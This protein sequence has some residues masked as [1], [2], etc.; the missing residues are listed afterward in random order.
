[1]NNNKNRKTYLF[2]FDISQKDIEQKQDSQQINK[3]KLI[4]K[5]IKVIPQKK[6]TCTECNICWWCDLN[7][8]NTPIHIPYKENLDENNTSYDC[9]GYF[10]SYQCA[11]SYNKYFGLYKDKSEYLIKYMYN[12]DFNEKYEIFEAPIKTIMTKYGGTVTPEEYKSYLDENLMGNNYKFLIC[13]KPFVVNQPE[14]YQ[15]Q[16]KNN[17]GYI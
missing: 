16:T 11:Y 13:L 10:C 4:P 12:K 1:M 2:Y 8:D 5:T 9:Y 7:I 14:I 17:T 6:N 3:Q 15:I